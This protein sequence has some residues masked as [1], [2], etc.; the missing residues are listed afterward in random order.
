MIARTTLRRIRRLGEN[1]ALLKFF[2]LALAVLLFWATR[3]PE[4]ARGPSGAQAKPVTIS[5]SSR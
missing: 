4:P 1:N 5:Q 2:A 3:A